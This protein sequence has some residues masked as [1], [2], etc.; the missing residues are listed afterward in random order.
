MN[1]MTPT[2]ARAI[3]A[4]ITTSL[5]L[6]SESSSS[7][8]SFRLL[9]AI[10]FLAFPSLTEEVMPS[11]HFSWLFMK[12]EVDAISLVYPRNSQVRRGSDMMRLSAEQ[13]GSSARHA[14]SLFPSVMK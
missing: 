10:L 4:N 14:L 2:V 3:A 6:P 8:S 1:L 12:V 5:F 9:G 7:P 11:Q 13:T